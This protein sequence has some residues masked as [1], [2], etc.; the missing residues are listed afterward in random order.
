MPSGRSPL[1]NILL[2]SILSGCGTAGRSNGSYEFT[3]KAGRAHNKICH[4][5]YEVSIARYIA[6]SLRLRIKNSEDG[7]A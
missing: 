6:H 3:E 2:E 4:R 5:T 7:K 1:Q